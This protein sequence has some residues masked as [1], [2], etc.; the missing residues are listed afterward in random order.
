MYSEKRRFSV[1]A[2][3]IIHASLLLIFLGGIIDGLFGFSGFMSIPQG[4]QSNV[5]ELKNGKKKGLPFFVKCVSAGQEN[6]EDGTPKKW[7]SDLAVISDNQQVS[8]KQIVVND[9]LVYRG[10]RFFQA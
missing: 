2:V 10:L 6:Y 8:S 4:Q 9:P 5:I 3:Y 7:W 1:M